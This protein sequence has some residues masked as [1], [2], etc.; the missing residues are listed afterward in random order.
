[1]KVYDYSG[2]P[3][4]VSLPDKKITEI[5]VV[6]LSGDETGNVVFADGTYISFDASQPRGADMREFEGAYSLL[7]D[8]IFHW[9]D[10]KPTKLTAYSRLARFGG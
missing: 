1:M 3:V 2:R 9:L 5:N 7:G 10:F 6:V 4:E 8:N